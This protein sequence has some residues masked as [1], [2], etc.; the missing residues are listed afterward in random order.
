MIFGKMTDSIKLIAV[1][2]ISFGDFPFCPGIGVRSCLREDKSP[3][4]EVSDILS[5]GDIVFGNLETCLS[6]NG[7]IANELSSVEMR[8]KPESVHFLKEAGFNVLNLA[9][10]HT[11][12]HGM[13][14]FNETVEILQ[15]ENI[16]VIGLR[17][18]SLNPVIMQCKGRTI[19]FL[20]FAFEKDNYGN[21]SL[22]Y[23]YG[24]ACS[25]KKEITSLK[26]KVDKLIISCHWGVE[27]MSKPSPYSVI[28]GRKIIDW[29]ADI[30][31]GHHSHVMQGIE[32][33]KDGL[34][35]YS[36]GNFLFD[37]LWDEKLRN[38]YIVTIHMDGMLTYDLV[39]VTIA[40][41][42]S[43]TINPDIQEN[44]QYFDQLCKVIQEYGQY[45]D[46]ERVALEYYNKYQKMLRSNRAKTYRFFLRNLYRID[47][48]LLLQILNRTL[49]RWVDRLKL[50]IFA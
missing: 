45:W 37:M 2:D 18:E 1:G 11:M 10:N 27:F 4:E 32:H 44:L 47:R 34:I 22:G 14:A 5:S 40:G 7:L 16:H 48:K 46:R 3:F 13:T 33:Y 26:E 36:L 17:G 30:V 29:G 15:Q 39:P 8:G 24:P 41:N 20:G 19:G 6:N 49:T 42:Y 12:Q 21:K 9:N 28:L 50:N 31:L 25:L 38:S 23:S 35:V 43:I